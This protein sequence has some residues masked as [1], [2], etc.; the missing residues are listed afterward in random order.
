MGSDATVKRTEPTCRFPARRKSRNLHVPNLSV[1]TAVPL[2]CRNFWYL[3]CFPE[4]PCG[5]HVNVHTDS[6]P[7][8]TEH[9]CGNH[10]N[11]RT[12]SVRSHRATFSIAHKFPFAAMCCNLQHFCK[13]KPTD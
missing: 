2:Q 1:F 7:L 11:V 5:N 3:R 12:D 8:P 10:V 13:N 4:H 6:V 9:P